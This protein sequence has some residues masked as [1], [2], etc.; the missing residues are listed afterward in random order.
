MSYPDYLL[1]TDIE[2]TGLRPSNEVILEIACFVAPFRDPFKRSQDLRT[3]FRLALGGDLYQ[4]VRARDTHE[5]RA[6]G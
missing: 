3:G 4:S 1:W 6:T 2:T 5:K